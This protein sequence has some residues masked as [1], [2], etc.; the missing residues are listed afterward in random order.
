MARKRKSR[1]ALK[2]KTK[3]IEKTTTKTTTKLKGYYVFKD[4]AGW[5]KILGKF[6]TS[7][8]L[9]RDLLNKCPNGFL[10]IRIKRGK[11][12]P[13][14]PIVNPKT[15]KIDRRGLIAAIYRAYQHGHTEVLKRA[16]EILKKKYGAGIKIGNKVWTVSNGRIVKLSPK[17]LK[18][19]KA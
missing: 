7:P 5:S 16:L 4:A 1:T 2:T 3:K 15:C 8:V 13:K 10:L 6:K 12:E 19:L 9:R 18:H 11:V 14:Y 17:G